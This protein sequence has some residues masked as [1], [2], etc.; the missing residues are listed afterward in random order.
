MAIVA[1]HRVFISVCPRF[2]LVRKNAAVYTAAEY[3]SA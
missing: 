2:Q 1:K 3:N